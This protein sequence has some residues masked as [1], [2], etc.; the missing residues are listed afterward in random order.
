MYVLT[1]VQLNIWN[2]LYINISQEKSGSQTSRQTLTKGGSTRKHLFVCG[3]SLSGSI[4]YAKFWTAAAPTAFCRDKQST[5]VYRRAQHSQRI[6]FQSAQFF[7]AFWLFW[8]KFSNM[9]HVFVKS[10]TLIFEYLPRLCLKL[11]FF[12]HTIIKLQNIL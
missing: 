5:F 10:A 7:C 8:L 11:S 9:A 4:E 3:P 6:W 12:C 1:L 2:S